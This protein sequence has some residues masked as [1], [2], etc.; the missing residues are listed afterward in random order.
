LLI[1][2]SILSQF[3]KEIYIDLIS[4]LLLIDCVFTFE[5]IWVVVIEHASDGVMEFILRG[6]TDRVSDGVVGFNL[7]EAVEFNL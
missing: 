5:F 3:L 2:L 4:L 7:G 6:V 1:N